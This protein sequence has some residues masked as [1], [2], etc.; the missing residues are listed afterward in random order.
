MR[1]RMITLLT[2]VIAIGFAVGC[3]RD[4]PQQ[5]ESAPSELNADETSVPSKTNALDHGASSTHPSTDDPEGSAA[6]EGDAPA[7][8]DS[9]DKDDDDK[10]AEDTK[11]PEDAKPGSG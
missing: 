7:D 5:P 2:L 6:Q 4:T 3:D 9:S 8:G 10:E 11:Q 1:L